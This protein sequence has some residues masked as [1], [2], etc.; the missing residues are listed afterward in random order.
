LGVMALAIALAAASYYCVEAPIRRLAQHV[1][2]HRAS[3]A[4]QHRSAASRQP[5][6]ANAS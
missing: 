5:N 4:D 1:R 6:P 2:F 3:V